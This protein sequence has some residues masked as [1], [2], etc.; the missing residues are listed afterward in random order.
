MKKLI[1]LFLCIASIGFSQTYSIDDYNLFMSGNNLDFDINVNTYYN[2]FDT[3]NI[4][5]KIIKDSIPVEWEMSFCF[6]DCYPV[7]V[8]NSQSLFLPMQN[9]YL[10]CHIYPNGVAGEGVIQ[11]E[12]TTNNSQKDTVSWVGSISNITSSFDQ[13]FH[14][15]NKKNLKQ[16]YDFLGRKINY[17]TNSYIFNLFEDGRVEK[18]LIIE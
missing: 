15:Q 7:G 13:I 3:C 11:M 17:K 1:I 2:S 10:N 9:N 18:R 12:I 14:S 5:W 6:P 4:S 16:V 8:V